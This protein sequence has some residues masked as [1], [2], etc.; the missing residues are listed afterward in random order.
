[1]NLVVLLNLGQTDG[2]TAFKQARRPAAEKIDRRER[3]AGRA[4]FPHAAR[5]KEKPKR[6]KPS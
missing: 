1:M 2:D 6:A 3:A 4:T 5:N